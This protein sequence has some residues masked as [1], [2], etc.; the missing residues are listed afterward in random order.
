MYRIIN[1]SIDKI[2]TGESLKHFEE[3]YYLLYNLQKLNVSAEPD[4]QR[5]YKKFWRMGRKSENYYKC[6]FDMLEDNKN[7]K[8][9]TLEFVIKNL[10]KKELYK[11]ERVNLEF[12]FSTKLI[13]MI[14]NEKPIYDSKISKFYHLPKWTGQ[15]LEERLYKINKIYYFLVNE[16]KRVKYEGLLNK[17]INKIR[18]HYKLDNKISDEKIMDS[19]IWMFI[20][21]AE[22]DVYRITV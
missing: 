19:I 6:Y 1:E 10:Y 14:N 7:N 17:S 3:Y 22:S 21:Y 8:D 2:I 9:I 16:F 15:S 13:H 20:S 18:K 11:N 12:S 5:R 4:Y